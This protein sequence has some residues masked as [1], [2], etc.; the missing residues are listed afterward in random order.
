MIWK[1]IFPPTTNITP[2][3]FNN[4]TELQSS[5]YQH[6]NNFFKK[7][8][9][10]RLTPQ[11]GRNSTAADTNSFPYFAV[12]CFRMSINSGTSAHLGEA[13]ITLETASF[14]SMGQFLK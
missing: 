6:N 3:K 8:L 2:K 11:S 10:R 12:K 7:K 13:K 14:K 4:K 5:T 1:I 9:T